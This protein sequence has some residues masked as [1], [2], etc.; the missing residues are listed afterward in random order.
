MVPRTIY[1]VGHGTRSIE[2]FC[3]LLRLSQIQQLADVRRHPGSRL[4]PQFGQDALRSFLT[5]A[6]INYTW[7][8]ALGGRRQPRRDSR[9]TA[10]RN[11]SF[12]GYADYMETPA[13]E[14][15]LDD[16]MTTTGESRLAIMCAERVWWRC[17][18]A[19][20]ADALCARGIQVW[21]ILGPGDVVEH[22]YSS[23]ARIVN[24][25]LTYQLEPHL[26]HL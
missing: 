26:P 25:R 21:H 10:W 5:A 2:S 4:H 3:D 19:M 8:P 22:R 16:L 7:V 6:G 23:P 11:P 9:N 13:F 12:R 17:H 20:I 15:A 1:T 18:R 24:G 14:A